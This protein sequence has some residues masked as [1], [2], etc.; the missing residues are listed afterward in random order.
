[1]ASG[2]G[3][4]GAAGGGGLDSFNTQYDAATQQL[5]QMAFGRTLQMLGA[6]G[7]GPPGG[8]GMP[9]Q[10]GPPMGPQGAPPQM[11][12]PQGPP[13]GGAPGG[14]GMPPPGGGPP[15]G[16]PPMGGGM[17]PPGGGGMQPQGQ[18]QGQQQGP[19]TLN[20]QMIMQKVQ[21]AN[22]G[23]PPNA[24]AAAIDR[25]MPLMS[26][27]SQQQ[28][29]EMSMMIREQANRE[30]ER[31]NVE[32]E[33]AANKR[34]AQGEEKVEQGEK[35]LG[36]AEKALGERQ[37]EFNIREARLQANSQIRADQGWQRLDQQRQQI[38]QR[39]IANKDRSQIAGWRQIVDAQHKRAMEIIAASSMNSKL[40]DKERAQ[41]KQEADK[42]RDEAIE[43][44][45]GATGSSTPTGGTT[46]KPEKKIEEQAPSGK[47]DPTA[48]E[49]KTIDG[50]TYEK[51]DGKWYEKAPEGN[52]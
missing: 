28:W 49:E 4:L 5:G 9:P 26:Q 31:H 2:L 39:M 17:P 6:G 45:R 7:G 35:R 19:P 50:K 34:I 13:M 46:A 21:Q 3:A 10:G 30:H 42:M 41:L 1:M 12:P 29:R 16:G 37:R 43:R 44:V 32:T 24:M 25:F 36:I 47:M 18:P 14:G 48:P 27:Q 40:D 20:W 51:R 15:M 8:G 33:E 38:E 22:P 23:L 52:L 11:Q